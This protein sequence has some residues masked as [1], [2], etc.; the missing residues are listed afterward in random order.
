MNYHVKFAEHPRSIVDALQK[1]FRNS[2]VG[3]DYSGPVMQANEFIVYAR[4]PPSR[5]LSGH[6]NAV[7]ERTNSATWNSFTLAT[8]VDRGIAND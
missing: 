1:I 8:H 5:R 3:Y 7:I 4:R 6:F 2:V